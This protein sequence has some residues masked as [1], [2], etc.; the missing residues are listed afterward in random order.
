MG[1]QWTNRKISIIILIIEKVFIYKTFAKNLF[2]VRSAFRLSLTVSL[3]L[4]AMKVHFNFT[5]V[6]GETV[7]TPITQVGVFGTDVILIV[8]VDAMDIRASF[9]DPHTRRKYK[10]I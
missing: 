6:F 9:P 7:A 2:C 10:N 3:V 8:P 5:L 4:V 1:L